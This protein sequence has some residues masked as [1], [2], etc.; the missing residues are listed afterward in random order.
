MAERITMT[1]NIDAVLKSIEQVGTRLDKVEAAADSANRG[2]VELA[3]KST[4][5]G[6][7]GG[8]E[9]KT[10]SFASK[11]VEALEQNADLVK[12]SGSLSLDI[13][14]AFGGTT[15]A[16]APVTA[17]GG[18]SEPAAY[19]IGLQYAVTQAARPAEAEHFIYSRFS[20]A[21]TNDV[22]VVTELG[23]ERKWV[24][25]SFEKVTQDSIILSALSEI[26][27]QAAF[28][29]PELTRVIELVLQKS[30]AQ[31][32]DSVLW[33]GHK[34]AGAGAFDGLTKLTKTKTSTYSVLA[35]AVSDGIADL[36]T[37]GLVPSVLVMSPATWVAQAVKTNTLGDY[38]SGS[39]S[40][41]M[42]MSL[43]GL[44]VKLSASI[45][46]GKAL[47]LDARY[48][49]LGF[50]ENATVTLG[51]V[52]DQFSRGARTIRID[53]RISPAVYQKEAMLLVTPKAAA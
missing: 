45:P 30:L 8:T 9:V 49:E 50:L 35:D 27:D 4:T 11:V 5:F 1:Q 36:Q 44:P 40:Q 46:D 24:S 12:K 29:A 2:V 13:K 51:Y 42:T 20:N 38:L 16:A 52:N 32:L 31:Q 21:W 18:I 39:Y 19:T 47:I 53:S 15:T 10:K 43:R 7:Q 28:S 17:T 22:A 25:P 26:S 48:V 23:T 41:P 33:S 3:Q 6:V 37:I 34:V 14:D